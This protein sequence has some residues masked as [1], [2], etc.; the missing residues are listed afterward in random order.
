MLTISQS[1]GTFELQKVC[2]GFSIVTLEV[3][4]WIYYDVITTKQLTKLIVITHVHSSMYKQR[5]CDTYIEI[6]INK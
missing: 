3:L 5:N 6:I 1:N 4:Q 2:I